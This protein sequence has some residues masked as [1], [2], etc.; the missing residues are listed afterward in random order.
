MTNDGNYTQ[1][2]IEMV[3]L[4]TTPQTDK[5][6]K[7]KPA[8]PMRQDN[9]PCNPLIGWKAGNTTLPPGWKIKR[10]EYANQT[11]YFYMSPKGD[12]IKSRR[13]VIDYMFDDGGYEEKDFN[14][15]ISGAKQRKVA[16][17]ELYENKT[18][19]KRKKKKGKTMPED[20]DLLELDIADSDDNMDAE[21]EDLKKSPKKPKIDKELI[22]P[23][24][25]SGRVASKIKERRKHESEDEEDDEDVEDGK[26]K[27][28][29]ELEER[30]KR[31]RLS[32]SLNMPEDCLDIKQEEDIKSEV[33]ELDI[34][35]DLDIKSENAKDIEFK[36]EE[37]EDEEEED[38]E[39]E[40]EKDLLENSIQYLDSQD[41][42]VSLGDI[43]VDANDIQE[44]KKYDDLEVK[45]HD[46]SSLVNVTNSN[47][48]EHSA[49]NVVVNVL[50]DIVSTI[51]E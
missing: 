29:D 18:S 46:G 5:N 27:A 31:A 28:E 23:T 3:R 21:T 1:D 19:K 9:S 16:L 25:R 33:L 35:Y 39:D 10:H 13:G 40:D 38:E 2:Q 43:M 7:K 15:V 45:L 26:R 32:P 49:Y 6:G 50:T 42:H 11:V 22:Q 47:N 30:L 44:F 36:E 34:Q 12:I 48:V 14:I 41:H 51:S 20:P 8:V 24:R 37:E 4:Q 17:Q